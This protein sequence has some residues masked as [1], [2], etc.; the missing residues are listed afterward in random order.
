MTAKSN[1][2][3]TARYLAAPVL[4]VAL[5]A[6]ATQVFAQPG[7]T[8]HATHGMRPGMGGEMA[9]GGHMMGRQLDAVGATAD[10]KA[11]VHS[12]MKSAHD[13]LARQR[14]AA[15]AQRQAMAALLTAPV[16]D[17]NAAEVLRLQMVAQHEAMSKRR[18]DAMLDAATVLTAEQRQKL[19]D[20][21]KQRG[22]MMQR[23]FRERRALEAPKS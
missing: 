14:E 17:R 4:A 22:D 1:R 2:G 19:A 15:R 10:Q 3:S 21:M 20:R 23:H 7:A 6:A 16:I 18:L 8:L 9:M 11:Q 5:L 12:I 13:D